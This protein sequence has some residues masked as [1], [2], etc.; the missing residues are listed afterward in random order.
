[1][2][3]CHTDVPLPKDVVELGHL[4]TRLDVS[5]KVDYSRGGFPHP[6][7]VNLNKLPNHKKIRTARVIAQRNPLRGFILQVPNSLLTKPATPITKFFQKL[8]FFLFG[9]L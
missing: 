3:L 7:C 5:S 8:H 6:T 2:I 4:F 9:V 1:M